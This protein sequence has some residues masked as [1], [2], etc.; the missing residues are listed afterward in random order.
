VN[1]SI[2][3][4]ERKLRFCRATDRINI[5]LK[6]ARQKDIFTTEQILSFQNDV[7]EFA[8]DWL[9]LYGNS[10]MTNY[11][12]QLISGHIAYFMFKWKNLYWHSQQGWWEALNSL[13][14]TFYF[15]RTQRGGALNKGKGPKTKLLPLG[16]WLQRCLLWL[17]GYNWYK[18]EE[19][20]AAWIHKLEVHPAKLFG[21][22]ADDDSKA[23]DIH[24]QIQL[25][26]YGII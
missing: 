7:D 19:V 24:G 13:I 12:H 21:E 15:R 20:L 9:W 3:D 1:I 4:E 8:Q 10:A 23:D 11:I 5:A 18:I 16:K 22:P 26:D 2:V 14:K 25:D 6:K 17:C